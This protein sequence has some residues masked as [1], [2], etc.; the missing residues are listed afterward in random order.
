MRAARPWRALALAALLAACSNDVTAPEDITPVTATLTAD[1]ATATAFVSLGAQPRVVTG[2][3]TTTAAG[4]DI[5]L[6]ATNVTLNAAGGVT[7]YCLCAN[8]SATDAAVMAMT[9]DAQLNGFSAITSTDISVTAAFTAD[10]FTTHKWY[11]Y[12]LTG[13]DH[14]IWPTFNVY[15]VK[16]GSSIYKVQLTSYYGA[17]GTSRQITIRSALIRS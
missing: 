16:R 4:W 5:G 2:T 13:N 11:R 3:D 6:N 1:A 14:Q 8:E 9:P 17:T 15:L 10:A 7:A 12:N